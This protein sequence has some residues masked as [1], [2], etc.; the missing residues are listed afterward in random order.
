M[1]SHRQQH[2]AK[3]LQEELNL[4][5]SAELTDPRL[6]DA[7][8]NVTQVAV[9][10]DLRSARVYVE[11]SLPAESSRQVLAAL[12][13]AESFLR[14]ALVENVNLRYVP[15]LSFHIDDT[16]ARGQRVDALLDALEREERAPAGRDDAADDAN[17]PG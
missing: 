4:L 11:H 15:H 3:L 10:A 8:V 12:A 17:N 13:H 7:M 2:I 5:V 9:S 14:E 1:P 6:A 16:S